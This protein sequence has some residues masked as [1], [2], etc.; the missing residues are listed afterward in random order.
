M[1][2]SLPIVAALAEIK[3]SLPLYLVLQALW[4]GPCGHVQDPIGPISNMFLFALP[5]TSKL[6]LNCLWRDDTSIT[7][8]QASDKF[9]KLQEGLPVPKV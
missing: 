7:V 9:I 6:H 4:E 5:G 1:S 8:F 2:P 3:D